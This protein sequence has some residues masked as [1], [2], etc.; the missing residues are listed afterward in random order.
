MKYL[1]FLSL[2]VATSRPSIEPMYYEEEL[3]G[4]V[5]REGVKHYEED[6]KI[7]YFISVK[8]IK[9]LSEL[10]YKK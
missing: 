2:I 1:F 7:V 4:A 8:Q 9:N 5:V 6:G 3:Y 10:P